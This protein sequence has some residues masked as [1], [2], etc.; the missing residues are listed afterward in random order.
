MIL[1]GHGASPEPAIVSAFVAQAIFRFI[2]LTR[3]DTVQPMLLVLLSILRMQV[4]PPTEACG[5][6]RRSSRIFV[7]PVTDVISGAVGLS[8]ENDIGSR[9]HNRVEFLVLVLQL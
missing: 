4:V 7:K 1:D 3:L 9:M 6:A 2:I 8:A 5:R